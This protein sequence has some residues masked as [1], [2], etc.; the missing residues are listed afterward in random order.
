MLA[1]VSTPSVRNTQLSEIETIKTL[2]RCVTDP[3]ARSI[4]RPDPLHFPVHFSMTYISYADIFALEYSISLRR[5]SQRGA[6]LRS[7]WGM[8]RIRYW[9]LQPPVRPCI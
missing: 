6:R 5:P 7:D 4:L 2:L 8:S 3:L 1:T 9:T